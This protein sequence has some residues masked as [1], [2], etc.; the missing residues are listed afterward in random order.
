M[1]KF[2][3]KLA[4]CFEYTGFFFLHVGLDR[5]ISIIF[6]RIRRAV[7]CASFD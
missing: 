7:S 2:E 4:Y 3:K 5:L 6:Q 1:I